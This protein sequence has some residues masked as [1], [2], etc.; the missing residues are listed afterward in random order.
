MN[1]YTFICEI[2][3]T[4]AFSVSGA[5]KGL[6]HEDDIF[7]CTLLGIVTAC[8]GGMIRDV[9]IGRIPPGSFVDPSYITVAAATTIV[10]FLIA[11]KREKD[12][13]VMSQTSYADILFVMDSIGLGIFA[14]IGVYVAYQIYG[15][16]NGLLLTFCGLITGVG[17]GMIRDVLVNVQPDVLVKDVYAVAALIGAYIGVWL[18]RL[19]QPVLAMWLP[20]VCVFLIRLYVYRHHVNLPK[21]THFPNQ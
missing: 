4:I 3:G 10:V 8:C 1:T 21:V 9:T 18:Y 15:A 12:G 14:S 20:V 19:N 16:D 17:G 2:I 6:Q 11:K 7:G 13:K 5:L